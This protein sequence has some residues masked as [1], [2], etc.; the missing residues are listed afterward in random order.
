MRVLYIYSGERKNKF[1]GKIGI[2][3]P[4]TQFYGLN[5]LAKF[6]IDAQFKEPPALLRKIL[7]FRLTHMLSFF[8]MRGYDVVFGSSLMYM[9]F[10]QK[11]F[12]T[13][14]KYVLLN[15]GFNRTLLVNKDKKFKFKIINWLLGELDWVVCL[16]NYQ[17]KFFEEFVP[18]LRGEVSFV[19]LGV[20]TSYCRPIYE[21][22]KNFILSAGRDNGR[23]YKTVVDVAR[24]M[25]EEE[26]HIVASKRNLKG[27]TDIPGNVKVFFDLSFEKLLVEY[28]EARILLLITHKDDYSDGSPDSGQTVLLDAMASGLPVIA[29]RKEH[30]KDYVKEDKEF[31]AVDFYDSLGIKKTIERLNDKNMA[32]NMAQSAREVVENRFSTENMANQ[33][34]E[35]FK[36]VYER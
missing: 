12:R 14:T 19:P 11:I 6:G 2:D 16:S 20:D 4:D 25:P 31:L 27:V 18:S 26:F 33:L 36:K 23:D 35:V 10:W 3:Y 29:S 7:G 21:G 30:L 15:V 5:H 1:K 22:R 24:L 9:L 32:Q 8:Y 13:K 17:K 28:E 34:A